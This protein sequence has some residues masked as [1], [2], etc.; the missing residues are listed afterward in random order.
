[1]NTFELGD[2]DGARSDWNRIRNITDSNKNQLDP[3][4]IADDIRKFKGYSEMMQIT[5][6]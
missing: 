3:I 6:K 2:E 1:V 4:Y 5:Q